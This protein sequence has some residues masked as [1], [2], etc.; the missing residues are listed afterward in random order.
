MSDVQSVAIEEAELLKLGPSSVVPD[1]DVMPKDFSGED[2]IS[3]RLIAGLEAWGAPVS[4]ESGFLLK[5]RRLSL[6]L[7]LGDLGAQLA[8]GFMGGAESGDAVVL[9]LDVPYLYSADS[10]GT[11]ASTLSPEEWAIRV[12]RAQQLESADTCDTAED[13]AFRALASASIDKAERAAA[14]VAVFADKVP[15]GWSV[16]RLRQ[17]GLATPHRR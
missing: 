8:G 3:E 10:A 16:W 1:E 5:N 14:R 7:G 15:Q 9:M 12:E 6:R 2:D 17:G 11:L 4:T 13:V